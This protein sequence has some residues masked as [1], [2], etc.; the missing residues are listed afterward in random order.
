MGG[1]L[2]TE[3]VILTI[4]AEWLATLEHLPVKQPSAEK[5]KEKDKDK[6]KEKEVT[7]LKVSLSCDELRLI[8]S[9]SLGLLSLLQG[10]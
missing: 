7:D 6:E 9:K 5:E 3:L 8:T 4:L 10:I 1:T 2:C